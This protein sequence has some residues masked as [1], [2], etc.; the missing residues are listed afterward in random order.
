MTTNA[1]KIFTTKK[2]LIIM[3]VAYFLKKKLPNQIFAYNNNNNQS[4]GKNIF[5]KIKTHQ[6]VLLII[7]LT[8]QMPFCQYNKQII[9]IFL[10]FSDT[11]QSDAIYIHQL[12]HNFIVTDKILLFNQ[13]SKSKKK[14]HVLMLLFPL[15]WEFL[16][17][18]INN[19]K[20]KDQKLASH[21]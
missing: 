4:Q 8:W 21:L 15:F 1:R 6:H 12:Y 13:R 7:F 16:S 9:C 14:K 2:G 5:L 11:E 20:Y 19:N 3:R 17:Y 18:V 10:M